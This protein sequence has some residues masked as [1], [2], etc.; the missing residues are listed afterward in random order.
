MTF[1]AWLVLGLA[2]GPVLAQDSGMPKSTLST[3][4][5][6]NTPNSGGTSTGMTTGRSSS[7]TGVSEGE[8]SRQTT[9][10]NNDAGIPVTP[11]DQSPA[12]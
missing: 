4:N 5:S 8:R 6:T 1:F 7:D 12:H 9:L 10:P 3:P 11:S 2:A